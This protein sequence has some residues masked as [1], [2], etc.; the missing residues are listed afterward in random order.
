MHRWMHLISDVI[1]D[2]KEKDLSLKSVRRTQTSDSA[3]HELYVDSHESLFNLANDAHDFGGFVS[4]R[5]PIDAKPLISLGHDE[6][7]LKQCVF[8]PKS[9]TT[10][11]GEKGLTSK[12]EGCGVMDSAFSMQELGFALKLNSQKL[13]RVNAYRSRKKYFDEEAV[14]VVNGNN[15]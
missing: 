15:T 6:A 7:T 14:T 12:D 1:S 10:P 8:S 3:S 5:K 11:D 4:F 9:W 13:D 2:V